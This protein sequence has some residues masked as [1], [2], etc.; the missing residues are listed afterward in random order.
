MSEEYSQPRG[1]NVKNNIPTIA[2][3]LY[4]RSS[5]HRVAPAPL[6]APNPPK[7]AEQDMETQIQNFKRNSGRIFSYSVLTSVIFTFS[8]Y[9]LYT[10]QVASFTNLVPGIPHIIAKNSSFVLYPN[11]IGFNSYYCREIDLLPT[12]VQN[13]IQVQF[14]SL[15]K[16]FKFKVT[17]YTSFNLSVLSAKTGEN[18]FKN[19]A[20]FQ[21]GQR[22]RN[23]QLSCTNDACEFKVVS[24][25]T[26]QNV[27]IEIKTF[28]ID[29]SQC[30]LVKKLKTQSVLHPE[31]CICTYF[32][33]D[34]PEQLIVMIQDGAP[35]TWGISHNIELELLKYQ[36][37][38][39]GMLL[40]MVVIMFCSVV[41]CGV[42]IGIRISQK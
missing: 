30:E 17:G 10:K 35:V 32:Y 15:Y 29:L 19:V 1:S 22:Q 2:D 16:E 13:K 21:D 41:L 31:Q 40:Q 18:F 23:Q 25:L 26:E 3:N 28:N 27:E 33:M 42:G 12:S 7:S 6:S 11:A 24:L 37:P 5:N 36:R 14:H 34:K 4:G 39:G 38:E 9:V 20:V 8:F